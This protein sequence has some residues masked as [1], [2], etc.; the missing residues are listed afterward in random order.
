LSTQTAQS[1][2]ISQINDT[3]YTLELNNVSDSTT[4]FSDGPNRIV[5]SVSTADFVGKWADWRNSFAAEAPNDALI[6]KILKQA[7]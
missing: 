6:V 3:T 2:S 4:P 1:G 7:S 5:T